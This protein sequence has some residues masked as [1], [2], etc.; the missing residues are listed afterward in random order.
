MYYLYYLW[1]VV[2]VVV[3][4]IIIKDAEMK[5]FYFKNFKSLFSEIRWKY[6]LLAPLGRIKY[7]HKREKNLY[8][9]ASGM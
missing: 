6:A 9:I 2:F 4:I 5:G 7:N 3:I 8:I 1:Q